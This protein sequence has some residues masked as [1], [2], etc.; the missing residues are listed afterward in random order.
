[1]LEE[2]AQILASQGQTNRREVAKAYKYFGIDPVH[3]AHLSDEIIVGQFRA[4]L[5][6]ISPALEDETRNMLRIIGQARQSSQILQEASNGERSILFGDMQPLTFTAIE[7]YAQALS[8]L[9]VDA[10]TLD[11]F[12]QAMFAFKVCTCLGRFVSARPCNLPFW[13]IRTN[14]IHLH[15]SFH[16]VTL[17]SLIMKI[18]PVTSHTS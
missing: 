18:F 4:R 10:E 11:E 6:D 15:N 5:Q 3:S 12:V 7:T 17:S 1:M 14:F 13:F 9:D 16:E 2:K 8:W